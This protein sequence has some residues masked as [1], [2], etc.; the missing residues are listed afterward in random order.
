MPFENCVQSAR[1]VE[2]RDVFKNNE[3]LVALARLRR[4]VRSRVECASCDTGKVPPF[5]CLFFLIEFQK[6][7]LVVGAQLV[8]FLENKRETRTLACAEKRRIDLQVQSP[9]LNFHD[10]RLLENAIPA[11][12]RGSG[13][14]ASAFRII[15]FQLPKEL[16]FSRSLAVAE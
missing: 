2:T 6:F 4:L 9:G 10:G 15:A 1:M 16:S 5:L 14:E 11:P 12:D 8:V 7:H 13:K 3:Q